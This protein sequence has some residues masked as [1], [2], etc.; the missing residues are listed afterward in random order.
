MLDTWTDEGLQPTLGGLFAFLVLSAL[1]FSFIAIYSVNGLIADDWSFVNLVHQAMGGHLSLGLLWAQHGGHR[2][3]FP[4]LMIVE[5]AVATHDNAKTT[6]LLSAVVLIV[7]FAVL[8]FVVG[9]YARRRVTLPMVVACGL[10]WFSLADVQNAL[11]AFQFAWYFVLL[12]L[13]LLLALLLSRPTDRPQ[14]WRFILAIA[15]AVVASYSS[16][17]GLLLWPIG[18]VALMWDLSGSPRH[19]HSRVRNEL[20]DLGPCCRGHDRHVLR[21]GLCRGVLLNDNPV[22]IRIHSRQCWECVPE[23]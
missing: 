20:V 15:A 2:M 23:Q 17:Q 7:S 1:Y 13:M 4:N 6:M 14:A 5:L 12:L 11:W 8:L 21:R 9:S 18:L 19:W 10:V 16:F 3:F 22:H